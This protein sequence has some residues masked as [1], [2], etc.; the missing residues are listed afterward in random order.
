MVSATLAF[1]YG[2]L[3]L[4]PGMVFALQGA[5]NDQKLLDHHYVQ[6]VSDDVAIVDCPVCGARFLEGALARHQRRQGH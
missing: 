2:G 4:E 5:P 1:S 3:A 6:Q